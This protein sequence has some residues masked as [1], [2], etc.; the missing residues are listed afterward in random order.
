MND[1]TLRYKLYEAAIE[2][3][4]SSNQY[5][6]LMTEGVLDWVK[7]ALT[8]ISAGKEMAGDL[9][10]MFKDKKNQIIY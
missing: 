5:H 10:N 1:V 7:D 8:S 2:T 6:E 9:K 3:G 4:I